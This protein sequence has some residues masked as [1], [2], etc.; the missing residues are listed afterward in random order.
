[1]RVLFLPESTSAS[2]AILTRDPAG[3]LVR[4]TTVNNAAV[5]AD[6]D[7]DDD[8]NDDNDKNDNEDVQSIIA[9][10]SELCCLRFYFVFFWW[11]WWWW[12]WWG[13]WGGGG[14][15][16]VL[17]FFFFFGGGESFLLFFCL[18]VL[19]F[20]FCNTTE[21]N[22]LVRKLVN[23]L[24]SYQFCKDAS[25]ALNKGAIIHDIDT[26]FGQLLNSSG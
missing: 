4:F 23:V 3:T 18:F 11:W 15:V 16:V 19:C 12:W 21:H 20:S 14:G 7:N 5:A 26:D 2:V 9:K 24:K 1:M 25:H 6:N 22:W 17:S 10:E 13:G 8:N